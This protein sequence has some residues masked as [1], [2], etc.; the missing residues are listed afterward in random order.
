MLARLAGIRSAAALAVAVALASLCGDGAVRAD[1]PAS[2]AASGA[3][4]APP[5]LAVLPAVSL[6]PRA[7]CDGDGS[8]EDPY[9]GLEPQ[10]AMSADGHALV[11]WARRVR[12]GWAVEAASAAPSEPFTT[13][14][15]VAGVPR[16]PADNLSACSVAVAMG[17]ADEAV[18][19]WTVNRDTVTALVQ[20]ASRDRGSGWSAPHTISARGEVYG[21][22][23][24][25]NRSGDAVAMWWR[26]ADSALLAEVSTRMPG[27]A[28]SAPTVVASAPNTIDVPAIA[29]AISASGEIAIAWARDGADGQIVQALT[30]STAGVWSRPA[31]LDRIAGGDFEYVRLAVRADGR[32]VAAWLRASDTLEP[33]VAR[34]A[35]LNP[36]RGW[37]RA[38]TVSGRGALVDDGSLGVAAPAAAPLT[39]IWAGRSS[40]CRPCHAMHVQTF[41]ADGRWSR[42]RLLLPGRPW[43][44]ARNREWAM[45]DRGDLLVVYA[46]ERHTR[47]G[48]R[49][50]TVA[51]V[52]DATGEWSSAMRVASAAP[53]QVAL[54]AGSLAVTYLSP[55][56]VDSANDTVKALTG[57]WHTP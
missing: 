13:P 47:F 45:N 53:A 48:V 1:A 51:R 5:T 8:F 21:A 2:I 20:L 17:A 33:G 16:A 15:A 6:S 10:L 34:A 31:V 49:F 7:R 55:A 32:A 18:A 41:G 26:V 9:L 50:R 4:G 40:A 27:G 36:A 12:T 37:S 30:R 14:V 3:T 24:A 42:P 57:T 25:M 44:R 39:L 23:V 29:G 38:S 22:N 46:S 11:T 54:G 19:A 52:R 35:V 28:W 43:R 56:H